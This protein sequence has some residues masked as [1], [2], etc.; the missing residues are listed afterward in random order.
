MQ[1]KLL[2]FDEE[3]CLN[4]AIIIKKIEP[5]NLMLTLSLTAHLS[6]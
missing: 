3:Q 2:H 5:T 4:C 1:S 6:L